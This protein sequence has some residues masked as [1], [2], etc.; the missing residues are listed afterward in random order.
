MP[1]TIPRV[2][3]PPTAEDDSTV[4]AQPALFSPDGAILTVISGAAAGDVLRL[5]GRVGD[6]VRIGKARNNDLVLK[7]ETVS[8]HHVAVERVASGLRV[9]DLESTN[10]VII[11]GARIK[12]GLAGP[13]T[14]MRIGDV[15]LLFGVAVTD[16]ALAPS[17]SD[18]FGI[19]RGRSLAMRR[20]FGVLERIAKTPVTVLLVGETGTGKDILARSIHAES[21]RAEQPF[22]IVDCGAIAS[23]LI[24]SELFGHERGAFTGAVSA[25]A[26]A[27][28]R[29][30]GGTIFLDE[31][32]ELSLELQP[33]LLRVLESR[34]FRRVGGSALIPADVRVVAATTKNLLDEARAGSFRDDLYF[35]LAVV[36]I[37]VP[38]LRQRLEDVPM[39]AQALLAACDATP[40]P[41][42]ERAVASLMAYAWPGNV[43]ELRNVLERALHMTRA[44]GEDSLKL[45]EFPPDRRETVADDTNAPVFREEE[46]YRESRG[47]FEAWFERRYV[48]WLL[49]RHGGNVSAAAR[50]ARMDR[51]HLTDLARKYDVRRGQKGSSARPDG[52]R[53]SLGPSAADSED[54]PE[55][56]R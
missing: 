6:A 23:S 53:P 9:T 50:A 30:A 25:R 28:E 27:F 15:E 52:E 46:T 26:G 21:D 54:S 7:D 45:V 18:R 2:S 55:R 1:K 36:T 49:A 38:P 13:G 14:I 8:R 4:S 32:G 16:V 37:T 29:A 19:A 31:I 20:I 11:G 40:P 41:L 39:I 43:R 56:T 44:L 17:Q 42:D 22:E 34:Q 47:R 33:K 10:G 51:N 3:S 5:P 48:D 24:E 35:R 12:E